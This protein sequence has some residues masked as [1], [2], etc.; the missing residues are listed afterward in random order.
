MPEEDVDS[1]A[2]NL[3]DGLTDSC[4][5]RQGAAHRFS[6]VEA[7]DGQVAGYGQAAGARPLEDF[8]GGQVVGGED[9][10]N[11]SLGARL[12]EAALHEREALRDRGVEGN[13][14]DSGFESGARDLG[15]VAGLAQVARS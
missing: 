4:K 10:V 14:D 7:D 8:G 9:S 13:R 15:A 11:G 2:G 6:A 5:V 12:V 3:L 1:R